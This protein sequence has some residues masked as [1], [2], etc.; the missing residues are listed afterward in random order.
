MS[1][2][3]LSKWFM[4]GF[5]VWGRIVTDGT[6]G[7]EESYIKLGDIEGLM[8]N[9][10]GTERNIADRETLYASWIFY[11]DTP[12]WKALATDYKGTYEIHNANGEIYDVT[13]P[14]DIQGRGRMMQIDCL[15][16]V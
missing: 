7:P 2:E 14:E 6:W 8:E 10:A 16:R 13:N 15:Q 12:A 3:Q 5:E 4:P 11:C 1:V 9:Q